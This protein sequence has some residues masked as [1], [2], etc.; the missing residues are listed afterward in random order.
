MNPLST[1]GHEP[2]QLLI[3]AKKEEEYYLFYLF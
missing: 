1:P 2:Q 3:T